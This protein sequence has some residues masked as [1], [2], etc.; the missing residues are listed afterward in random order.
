LPDQ[1]TLIAIEKD[2]K[3][4][5][6]TE[7][8][9]TFFPSRKKINKHLSEIATILYD[10]TTES[11]F[12][13][14]KLRRVIQY[15]KNKDEWE[16]KKKYEEVDFFKTKPITNVGNLIFFEQNNSQIIAIDAVKMEIVLKPFDTPIE[17]IKTLQVCQKDKKFYISIIGHGFDYYNTKNSNI[18]DITPLVNKYVVQSDVKN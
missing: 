10:E 4:I 2:N 9:T 5:L 12:V 14:E 15:K 17:F 11:L 7:D 8:V 13:G 18:C 1:K 3:R 6:S 16:I